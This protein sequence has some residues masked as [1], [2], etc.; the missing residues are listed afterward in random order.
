M[1]VP[2]LL[3]ILEDV[4]T[5]EDLRVALRHSRHLSMGTGDFLF[6]YRYARDLKAGKTQ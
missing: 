1:S 3:A 2:Q 4:S 5:P 6:E